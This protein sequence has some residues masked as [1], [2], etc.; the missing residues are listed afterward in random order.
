VIILV[1]GGRR[2]VDRKRAFA[3]LDQ[4]YATLA[5]SETLY[6]VQGCAPGA[7]RLASEW[8]AVAQKQGRNVFEIR[9]PAPWDG[10]YQKQAGFA[11]NTVQAQLVAH[12]PEKR[13]GAIAFPGGNG[14]ANQ[15]T[16][17]EACGVPVFKVDW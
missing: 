12:F 14:T 6:V 9:C 4:V 7:D 8:C 15:V 17:C 10:P 16:A 3:V 2:Y 1:T 13:R 5:P 11:R